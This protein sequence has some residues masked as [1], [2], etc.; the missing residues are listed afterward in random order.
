MRVS[1]CCRALPYGETYEDLGFCSE[2]MEHAVFEEE[3]R[4]DHKLVYVEE[5]LDVNV[6]AHVYCEKCDEEGNLDEQDID[7]IIKENK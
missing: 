4:C 1:N 7:L 5:E 2:C 3:E 6:H